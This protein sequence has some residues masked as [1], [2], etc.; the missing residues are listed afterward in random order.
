MIVA[1]FA[2]TVVPQYRENAFIISLIP[3]SIYVL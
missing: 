1:I 2:C 3:G